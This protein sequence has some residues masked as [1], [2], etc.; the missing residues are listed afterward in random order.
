MVKLP[1]NTL[2]PATTYV[3]YSITV[4]IPG[5]ANQL[6]IEQ[7]KHGVQS[8]S[9]DYFYF[10]MRYRKGNKRILFSARMNVILSNLLLSNNL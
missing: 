8:P 5:L 4:S 9:N 10:N 6:T 1:G 2:R 3:D 7:L